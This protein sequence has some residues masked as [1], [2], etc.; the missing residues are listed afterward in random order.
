MLRFQQKGIPM[1]YMSQAD[2]HAAVL[3]RYLTTSRLKRAAL[4]KALGCH[5]SLIYQWER[6]TRPI[7][8]KMAVALEKVTA[9]EIRRQCLHPDLYQ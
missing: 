8:P 1:F 4:A 2:Q 5:V 9:G 6:G 3:R 7:S